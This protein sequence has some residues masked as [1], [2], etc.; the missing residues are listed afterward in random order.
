MHVRHELL[1]RWLVDRFPRTRLYGPY[2][3]GGR[4]Y[5]QWMARGSALVQDVLPIL[6]DRLSDGLDGHAAS[7]LKAMCE[8]YA[9]YIERERRRGLPEADG[10]TGRSAT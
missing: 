5:F 1:F 8:R 9:S 7:R 4:S 6:E 10:P 3:H 2:T